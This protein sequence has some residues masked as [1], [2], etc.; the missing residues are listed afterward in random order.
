MKAF[1]AAVGIAIMD[2]K[3]KKIL[4]LPFE[5]RIDAVIHSPDPSA[6]VHAMPEEEVW[7]T[8]KKLGERDALSLIALTSTDQLQ[9][10][11]DVELWKK[12]RHLGEKSLH[13]LALLRDCGDKKVLQ[14]AREADADAPV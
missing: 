9:Y 12:D 5:E 14:W 1:L 3:I 11:L 2:T 7:L 8:I 4:D 10:I 13:W 6:L